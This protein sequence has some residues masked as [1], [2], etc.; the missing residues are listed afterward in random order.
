MNQEPHVHGAKA[1]SGLIGSLCLLSILILPLISCD[2]GGAADGATSDSTRVASSDEANTES[3]DSTKTQPEKKRKERTTSVRTAKAFRGD[4]V[5]PVIAEGTIRARRSAEIR[6]ENAGPVVRVHAQEGQTLRKGQ[7]IAKLDDREYEV[8]AEEARAKYVAAVSLLAIEDESFE[9]PERPAELQTKVDELRKLETQGVISREER[10]A[11]EVA[12]DVE[13]VK[14]GHYRLDI[15]ASRSGIA[16]ARAEL[17]RARINLERTEIRAPFSGVVS[18]LVL[19]DG[20]HVTSGQVICTLVNI[21]DLEAEVGVLESDIGFLDVGRAAL[22]SIPALGDTLPV[23]VDVISPRFDR[24]SRTCQVLLRIKNTSGRL[25]PGMFA[26]AV[27]AGQKFPDRLLV[28]KEAILT[29][30]GRPLLFKVEDNRA[31]WVY[32]DLGVQ[33]DYVVEVKAVLQGGT[34][35]PDDLVV[36]TNHL[37][38]SHEAKVKVKGVLPTRDPWSPSN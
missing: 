38:L 17:E 23:T 13:A 33:N 14:Q 11:R 25:R 7:L 30:D 12:L 2:S 28:P 21:T 29:R 9:I 8:E 31:K 22:L 4:L 19:N 26:R 15:L 3:D 37:T 6:S 20:E 35:E 10:L 18:G 1:L 5:I 32:I 36:V 34:L 27:V 16:G 24:D